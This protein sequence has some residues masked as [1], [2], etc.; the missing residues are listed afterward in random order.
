MKRTYIHLLKDWPALRWDAAV[1]TAPLAAARFA[2]GRLLGRMAALGFPLDGEAELAVLTEEV[3][4]SSAIEG[5]R[6]DDR[7]V[8]S[9]LARRLRID[10]GGIV[11]STRRIDGL[12]ELMLDA[13][14]NFMKPLTAGRLFGWHA[15]LFPTGRNAFGRITAGAWRK[16]GTA[17]MRVVS[18]PLGQ[19]TVQFEAPDARRVPGEMRAFLTWFNAPPASDP[20][21]HAGLAHFRFV[22]VHPFDDGNGRLA[23]AV[24][25][26]ALARSDGSPQR[27]YS[28]S[29]QIETERRDYY[30]ALEKSQAGGLDVT[31]WLLW[32]TGCLA[33]SLARAETTLAAILRKADIIRA[34]NALPANPRQRKAVDRLLDGFEGPF[35]AAKYAKMNACSAD[36][37]LR[38]ITALIAGGILA[39]GPSG[40][41][42]TAYRLAIE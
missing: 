25:E 29:A 22:T 42:S 3:V 34:L 36:T 21:L 30:A 28:M 10:T 18:G 20:V 6:L 13:T 40:G 27:F 16:P 8:R 4:R 41:R 2:Q 35:T 24:T 12:A 39:R 17:P 5:E 15:A 1:L 11:P 38:D 14:R 7:Q 32:F 26:M 33:R 23:R 19:E 37:A 31:P 9:S